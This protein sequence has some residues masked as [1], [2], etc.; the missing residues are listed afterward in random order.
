MACPCESDPMMTSTDS[1]TL[2]MD[3]S[4]LP[5]S[6]M[7]GLLVGGRDCVHARGREGRERM[8]MKRERKRERIQ[9]NKY[10]PNVMI[11]NSVH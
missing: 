6:S 1:E 3:T 4:A 5:L 11:N 9:L 2:P 8:K 10:A 7:L